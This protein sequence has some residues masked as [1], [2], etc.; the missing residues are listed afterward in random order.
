MAVFSSIERY[1]M[2]KKRLSVTSNLRDMDGVLNTDK[3]KN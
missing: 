3:I 1:T 2:K